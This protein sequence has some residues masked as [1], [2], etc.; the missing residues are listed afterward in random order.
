MGFGSKW[1]KCISS[2]LMSASISILV[3]GSPT[4][5]LY[6][7]RGVRQGDPF[8]PFLFIIAAEGLNILTK[9]AI[10]KGLFKGVEVGND[11]VVI[12]HLQYADDKIFFEEWGRSNTL[13]LKNIL[14]CFDLSSSLKVNFQKSCLFGVGV[15]FDEQLMRLHWRFAT[16][17][18]RRLATVVLLPFGWNIGLEAINSANYFLDFF[19]LEMQQS[20][21]VQNRIISEGSNQVMTWNWSRPPSGRTGSELNSLINLLQTFMFNNSNSDSWNWGLASNGI[22]TV[23]KLSTRI[24]EQSLVSFNSQQ[25]TSRNN[26]VPKKID[27]FIWRLLKKSIPVKLELDKRGINLHSLR[28]PICDEDLESVDHEF[29]ACKHVL[30]VWNRVHKNGWALDQ[31]QMLV[32]RAC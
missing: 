7:S 5:E 3:N 30:D 32:S 14:K 18:S 24:D 21:C 8:S 15:G 2:S 27:I 31:S 23:K 12:S 10:E 20:V 25:G 16:P 28:C 6:L 13:S 11:K 9:V 22:Y 26:L 19:R 29:I 4:N 1:I 17:S